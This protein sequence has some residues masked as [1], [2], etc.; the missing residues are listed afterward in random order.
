MHYFNMLLWPDPHSRMLYLPV[1]TMPLQIIV[2]FR[3]QHDY[4]SLQCGTPVYVWLS[5]G[6]FLQMHN[7]IHVL[8]LYKKNRLCAVLF[9]INCIRRTGCPNVYVRQEMP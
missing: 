4:F 1:T 2:L 8:H 7:I 9:S 3:G 6:M 5:A